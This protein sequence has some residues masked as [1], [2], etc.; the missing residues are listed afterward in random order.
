MTRDL[1]RMII[2]CENL[3]FDIGRKSFKERLAH[4]KSFALNKVKL[5]DLLRCVRRNENVKHIS[6]ERI[7]N[8]M[9]RMQQYI[10]NECTY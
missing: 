7:Y 5:G 10:F 1:L 3:K 9:L 2:L 6:D 8:Y 4:L